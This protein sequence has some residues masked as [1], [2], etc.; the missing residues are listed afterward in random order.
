MV[1]RPSNAPHRSIVHIGRTSAWERGGTVPSREGMRVHRRTLYEEVIHCRTLSY[2]VVH[3]THKYADGDRLVLCST[4]CSI[5]QHHVALC[6][7]MQHYA[8]CHPPSPPAFLPTVRCCT[9]RLQTAC[10]RNY[11]RQ[12]GSAFPTA[13]TGCCDCTFTRTHARVSAAR[14]TSAFN[15]WQAGCQRCASGKKRW[16]KDVAHH[17]R[18]RH[19]TQY[20]SLLL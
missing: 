14:C 15:P 6:S 2:T 17:I 10:I 12:S 9:S 1:A 8:R 16:K 19:C 20:S 4:L 7:I 5:M 3:G 11:S 13:P 18:T